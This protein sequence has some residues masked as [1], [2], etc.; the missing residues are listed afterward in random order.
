MKTSADCNSKYLHYD[1][2]GKLA[3]CW[4]REFSYQKK[5]KKKKNTD[6]SI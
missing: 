5:K 3:S 2:L 6:N 4:E 1:K